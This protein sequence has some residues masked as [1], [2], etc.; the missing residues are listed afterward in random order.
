MLRAFITFLVK[1]GFDFLRVDEEV[2][3]AYL[4]VLAKRVKSPATVR[5]YLS[6]LSASY[7]R[8]G[9]SIQSFS[10]SRVRRALAA[11]DR[12]MK[13]V[14]VPAKFV[15]YDVLLDIVMATSRLYEG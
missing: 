11:M 6:A 3:C 9:L 14:P 10:H 13:H 5:N 15:S 7:D 4:E 1:H 12:T 2:L 8:M